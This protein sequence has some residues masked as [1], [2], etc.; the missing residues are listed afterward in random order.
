[1]V[2]QQHIPAQT[3]QQTKHTT[4][5]LDHHEPV[6][7]VGLCTTTHHDATSANYNATTNANAT[8]TKATMTTHTA[9]QP[10]QFVTTQQSVGYAD[11]QQNQTTLGQQTT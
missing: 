10:R 3:N 7:P 4:Q 9:K 11:N 8:G 6:S 5:C 2:M 1:M